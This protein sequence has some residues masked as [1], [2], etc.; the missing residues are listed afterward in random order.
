MGIKLHHNPDVVDPVLIASW[1][2]IG[3]I[4]L[5]AVNHLRETVGAEE[6]GE[7]EPTEFFYPNKV[8]IKDGIL[9]D[10]DFPASRFFYKR[11]EKK[12]LIFFVGEEQPS[13]GG[14]AYAGGKRAYRMANLVMD[15][16]EKFGCRRVYSSGAAVSSIHHSDIP[17]VWAVPNSEHLLDEIRGYKNTVLM[18]DIEGRR[19]RGSISGLNGLLLGVARRRKIDA[20]CVMGEIPIYLQGLPFPYPKASKSVV[21]LLASI[22]DID[23][24][25]KQIDTLAENSDRDIERF[26]QMF[27]KEIREHIEKLR[28]VARPERAEPGPITLEDKRKILDDID[29][30]FNKEPKED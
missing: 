16:A 6:F 18:S 19:G 30:F 23:A 12:D 4:G 11:T 2:G 20:I 29:K 15:V 26:Y 21:E 10:V 3:N 8:T 22:L 28:Y 9:Q 1:P 27:P 5:I 17:K 7:I 25:M 14:A 24:D 13:T